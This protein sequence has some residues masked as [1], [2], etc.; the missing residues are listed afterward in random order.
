MVLR[1]DEGIVHLV[2]DPNGRIML[3]FELKTSGP[4][5]FEPGSPVGPPGL[6]ESLSALALEGGPTLDALLKAWGGHREHFQHVEE[7]LMRALREE[8]ALLLEESD[9]L[10]KAGATPVVGPPAG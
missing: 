1:E 6:D 3:A 2:V 8:T 10:E 9:L 7:E 4:V 5:A